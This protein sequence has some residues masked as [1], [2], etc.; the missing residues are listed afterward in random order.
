MSKTVAS[1]SGT[2]FYINGKP[3]YP[4]RT[5][6]GHRIEGMLMNARFV[7]ATFDDENPDTVGNWALPDGT[8]YDADRNTQQ[9]CDFLPICRDHGM[10]GFT[11]NLQG[12][13]PRGYGRIQT[14]IN[15]AFR[16]DGSLKDQYMQRVGKVIDT[17]D[18]LGM[19]VILGLFYFGQ[20]E[21]M[22][23]EDAIKHGVDNAVDWLVARGDRN[24]LVEIAN[25]SDINDCGFGGNMMYEHDI[26]VG[27]DRGGELIERVQQRS[28]GKLDT[29][30]GRLLCTTSFRGDGRLT[31][32]VAKVSDFILLHG[33]GIDDPMGLVPMIEDARTCEGYR[34]QPICINEDDHFNFDADVNHMIVA[35]KNGVGWGYYDH[36]PEGDPFEAGFQDMPASWA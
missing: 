32:P 5:W 34:G 25:E 26:L 1:L 28:E 8:P 10:T 33:N 19:V 30:A 21:N 24:V 15:S 31:P 23:G 9:F 12:G 14:W 16:P 17:A 4:G 20:D 2:D 18:R 13:S 27:K 36:R 3:T 11:I 35:V 22:E 7:Q 6:Q 29:P